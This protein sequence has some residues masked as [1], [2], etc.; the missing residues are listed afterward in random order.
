MKPFANIVKGL[1]LSRNLRG[2][3]TLWLSVIVYFSESQ[4]VEQHDSLRLD[5]TLWESIVPVP[6][7]LVVS[8]VNEELLVFEISDMAISSE[9]NK[10]D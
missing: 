9:L 2:C 5:S 3:L 8:D 1:L 4:D 7:S 10:L 6:L